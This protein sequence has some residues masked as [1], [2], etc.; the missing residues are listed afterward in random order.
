MPIINNCKLITPLL[1]ALAMSVLFW[2]GVACAPKADPFSVGDR[3]LAQEGISTPTPPPAGKV[4]PS[5]PQA[6]ESSPGE[7]SQE[8]QSIR[9]VDWG[10]NEANLCNYIAGYIISHG[11]ERTV[12]I[13]E[14]PPDGYQTALLEGE[15]D[16]VIGNSKE[17]NAD[18][19]KE[20]T[21][22]GAIID[23]GAVIV[24]KPDLRIGVN[25]KVKDRAPEVLEF[26]GKIRTADET[27]SEL[28]D[29]MTGGRT[30]IGVSVAALMFLKRNEALWSQWVSPDI[31]DKVQTALD[32]GKSSLCRNM[33]KPVG[34]TP[35]VCIDPE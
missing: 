19:Y 27:L 1:I 29:R 8:R 16:V 21:E 4:A 26:L 15:V 11:F 23:A 20:Q 5:K 35:S 31:A 30:G 18:W 25:S 12:K 14:T 22:L 24:E 7:A 10:D 17:G 13:I 3:K 2:T 28:A 32:G 6:T 9:F 33:Y 34:V